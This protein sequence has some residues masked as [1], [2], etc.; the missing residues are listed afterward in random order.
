[1]SRRITNAEIRSEQDLIDL[2]ADRT[3][4]PH[5]SKI[6]IEKTGIEQRLDEYLVKNNFVANRDPDEFDDTTQN[7]E[8]GSQWVNTL[9]EKIFT[10]VVDTASGAVWTQ[11]GGGIETFVTISA[12]E[13]RE[14]SEEYDLIYVVENE[15]IYRYSAS[16]LASEP[17]DGFYILKD[18]NNVLGRWRGLAG[19]YVYEGIGGIETFVTV[20]EAELRENNDD[21]ELIYVV[22]TETIYRY[23][24]T[25]MA[26]I[27]D[28]GFYILKDAL[29]SD[30]RWKGLAGRYILEREDSGTF[31]YS[32]T[33]TA[34]ETGTWQTYNSGRPF[35]E[36][37]FWDESEN[38]YNL[39]S[40]ASLDLDISATGAISYDTTSFVFD[41]ND[42][43]VLYASY[44]A[45]TVQNANEYDSGW[46]EVGSINE[47]P[48][49]GFHRIDLPSGFDDNPAG[50]SLTLDDG[51]DIFPSDIASRLI[52]SNDGAGTYRVI[53]D[54]EEL[55]STD[56]F[57]LICSKS[58][59]PTGALTRG[60]VHDAV[61]GTSEQV[62]AGF[63]TY[64]SL[65]TAIDFLSTGGR[66]L[67]LTSITENITWNN[68]NIAVEGKGRSTEIN[69]SINI[70]GNG[71]Y[72]KLVRCLDNVTLN[73]DINFFSESWV[74][75]TYTVTDNG[76]GN[77]YNIIEE[78]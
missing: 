72:L 64:T 9:T 30:G 78:V 47:L 15:T 35:I 42:K 6:Y 48:S 50:Y 37:Y 62:S 3:Y 54:V 59:R 52:F 33:I 32:H 22:E 40:A 16:G 29:V 13:A 75:P 19:R 2:G 21:Y 67:I 44:T 27:P 76:T 53:V 26:G 61:V 24:A 7:F 39:L 69:G 46:L 45:T 28:D 60:I 74:A 51:S 36:A 4:L 49:S 25:G 11:G 70:V 18:D 65:Q 31:I 63:A 56:M 71:N 77:Y 20:A 34:A 8:V 17:D 58:A 55:E 23:S 38:Q 5:S 12:A 41:S 1:M 57:R 43:I 14:D 73:G 68:S 10:L 66:I